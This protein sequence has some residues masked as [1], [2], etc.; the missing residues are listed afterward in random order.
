MALP[1]DDNCL[2]LTFGKK[3][4][5]KTS[6]LASLARRGLKKGL[7][8][9]S[10]VP[11]KGTFLFKPEDFGLFEFEPHSLIL[12]DE[13]NSVW[14]NRN[15]KNFKQYT[16]DLFRYQRHFDLTIHLFSQ[17]FDCD[18]KIRDLCDGLFIAK[19]L[20]KWFTWIKTVDKDFVITKA[21][22]YGGSDISFGLSIRPFILS[23]SRHLIFLPKYWK[24]FDSFSKYQLQSVN[25]F[26]EYVN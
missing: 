7:I 8:V 24:F 10:T 19:R 3:G 23:G 14:D 9:Y 15:F 25:E 1:I 18:K 20:G 2:Y 11:I 6:T 16:Q 12:I 26:T 21:S 17:S 13:V 4:C 22:D 5:G